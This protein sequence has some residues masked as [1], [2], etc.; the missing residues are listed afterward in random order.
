M[1]QQ[2]VRISNKLLKELL[3]LPPEMEIVGTHS[4]F[5]FGN[6]DLLLKVESPSFS[7]TEPG[8]QLPEGSPMFSTFIP[9]CGCKNFVRTGWWPGGLTD[10]KTIDDMWIEINGKV[11]ASLREKGLLKEQP[12]AESTEL[13]FR[14]FF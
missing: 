13:K 6:P 3:Q 4:D 1:K 14:E 7:D 5:T 2:I 8:R 12:A 10:Q 11:H 9:D